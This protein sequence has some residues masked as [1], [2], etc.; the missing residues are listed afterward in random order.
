MTRDGP[1]AP[2]HAHTVSPAMD[3]GG[4]AASAAPGKQWWCKRGVQG[5]EGIKAKITVP[6]NWMLKL[7]EGGALE[8]LEF[9]HKMTGVG[10]NSQLE[11]DIARLWQRAGFARS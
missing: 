9:G 2:G 5:V 1:G 6:Q 8:W 3:C 10:E 4:A 7:Y 11:L